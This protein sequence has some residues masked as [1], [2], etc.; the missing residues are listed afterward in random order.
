[1]DA[2]NGT[3]TVYVKD[4]FFLVEE[5]QPVEATVIKIDPSRGVVVLLPVVSLRCCSIVYTCRRLMDLFPAIDGPISD[6]IPGGQMCDGGGAC[7]NKGSV[8]NG[9]ILISY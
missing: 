1:M 3:K 4:L 7:T 8:F 5:N 6:Y 2:S 9:R